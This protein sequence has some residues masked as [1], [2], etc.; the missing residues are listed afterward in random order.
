MQTL[1]ELIARER[2][3]AIAQLVGSLRDE[4]ATVNSITAELRSTLLA[5]T[6]TANAVHATLLTIQQIRGQ[7]AAVPAVTGAEQGP[8]FDIRQYTAA[9]D[10]ATT[11]ARELNALAQRTDSTLPL[12]R[13]A[14]QDAAW[15]FERVANHLFW[16]LLLLIFAA[17][18]AALLAALAYR[19]LATK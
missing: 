10:A 2:E 16:L 17:A 9:L 14:T 6:D 1:P 19:R 3:A 7:F 15:Q 12:L 18:G 11:T 5:G 13:S 4:Q 8:P